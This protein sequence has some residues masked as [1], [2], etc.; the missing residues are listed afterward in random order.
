[1][2]NMVRPETALGGDLAFSLGVLALL[3]YLCFTAGCQVAEVA[4]QACSRSKPCP[5]GLECRGGR[6]KPPQG[7]VGGC[8][9]PKEAK[10]FDRP[11]LPP[12]PPPPVPVRSD[13][14]GDPPKRVSAIV[15]WIFLGEDP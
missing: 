8:T 4:E 14:G 5:A 11:P 15:A 9:E 1:M 10:G 3:L 2:G 13:W 6:C 12:M 7:C